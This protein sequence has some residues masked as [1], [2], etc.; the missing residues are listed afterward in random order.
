MAS[1]PVYLAALVIGF[2]IGTVIEAG[3]NASIYFKREAPPLQSKFVRAYPMDIRLRIVS[4]EEFARDVRVKHLKVT[5]QMSGIAAFT[6]LNTDPCLIVMPE[7]FK[8]NVIAREG[9]AW[10]ND[11]ETGRVLAHEILHCLHGS[12]HPTWDKI[13]SKS[14]RA[15]LVAAPSLR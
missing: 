6:V 7:G 9:K 1:L 2:S 5:Q 12:W 10:F 13:Q 4:A 14:D 8:I 3:R 15:P 11:D